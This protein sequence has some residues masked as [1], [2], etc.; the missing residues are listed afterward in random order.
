[1]SGYKPSGNLIICGQTF[2][3]DAPIINW[4]EGPGWDAT[5]EYCMATVNDGSPKCVAGVPYG[6]L[7]LGPYTKRYSFRPRL[8]HFGVNPPYEAVKPLIRQFVIHHDGCTSA[9]MCF[10]VLQNERGL[11]VHFLLDNDGTIYQTIDLGL[12]AYHAAEWNIDSI[13]VEMSNRGDATAYPGVYDSGRFGPKR[14]TKT[15]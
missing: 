9:D 8:R 13:G 15:C 3:A 1:M 12:M 2:K 7:P 11:S 10:S 4:R 5:R 14:N 6:K